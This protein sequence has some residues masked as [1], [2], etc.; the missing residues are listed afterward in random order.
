MSITN[1]EAVRFCN[2]RVR[3]AADATAQLYYQL[4]ALK[5]EWFAASMGDLI[6]VEGGG[7]DDGSDLDGRHGITGTDVINLITRAIELVND[8]EANSNAKLNTIINVAVHPQ[9]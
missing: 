2:E 6:T 8:Y 1:P 3:P 5:D 4:K 9:G 7:I